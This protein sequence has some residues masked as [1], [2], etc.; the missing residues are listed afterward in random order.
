LTTGVTLEMKNTTEV[1]FVPLELQCSDTTGN[2][3]VSVEFHCNNQIQ[4]NSTAFQW[5]SSA[6]FYGGRYMV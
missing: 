5:I 6:I 4:W 1:Q 3:V 2:Q